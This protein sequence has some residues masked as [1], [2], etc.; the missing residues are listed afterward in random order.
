MID[1][2]QTIGIKRYVLIDCENGEN[3]KPEKTAGFIR[4]KAYL[5]YDTQIICFIGGDKSQNKWYDKFLKSFDKLS[6]IYNITSVRI[7]T[8]GPNA[9]DN[10]LSV[11]LG[12]VLARN[13]NAEFIIIAQDTGYCAIETHFKNSGVAI[14]REV[15]TETE[16]SEAFGHYK[17]LQTKRPQTRK[18]LRA[19]I[20]RYIKKMNYTNGIQEVVIQRLQETGIITIADDGQIRWESELELLRKAPTVRAKQEYCAEESAPREDS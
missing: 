18:T 16:I 12:L 10:V 5:S 6:L 3:N 14:R 1:F 9:L 19:S 13:L 20:S 15:L 7:E 17:Q 8:V 11:Y 2:F 4:E